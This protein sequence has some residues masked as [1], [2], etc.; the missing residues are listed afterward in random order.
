MNGY[1][2]YIV[3]TK[4]RQELRAEEHLQQQGDEVFSP[5]LTI[6][7]IRSGQRQSSRSA[8]F[9]GY[10]FVRFLNNPS[11]ISKVRST[12]GVRHLL[13]FGSQPARLADDIVRD[14]KERCR[15]DNVQET[16]KKGQ[17]VR[18]ESGPFQLYEGIFEEYDGE[19]RAVIFLS[20]LNSQ[21]KLVMDLHDLT[22]A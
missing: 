11:L 8:L 2:W 12:R 19:R 9:P 21:Q 22:I 6:E 13:V 16:L 3:Q 1:D 5:F 20:L 14:I 15:G 17:K 7:N 10:L 18:I 4:P